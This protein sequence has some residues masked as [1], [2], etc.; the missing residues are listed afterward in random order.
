MIC[1]VR[2]P[3]VLAILLLTLAS[4]YAQERTPGAV[5]RPLSPRNANYTIDVRLDAPART[6]TGRETLAWTNIS[7]AA[8]TELQFHLYYNAWKND[9][10]TYMEESKLAGGWTGRWTAFSSVW[11]TQA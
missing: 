5:P 1:A 9:Q 2:A 8:A 4:A 3:A 7:T 6:L 11:R 10:S